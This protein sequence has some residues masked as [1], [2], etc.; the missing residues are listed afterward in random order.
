MHELLI[1]TF[2]RVNIII[3]QESTILIIHNK[4]SSQQ[5]QVEVD[6]TI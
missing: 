3:L 6:D 2:S 1:G 4:I 5:T